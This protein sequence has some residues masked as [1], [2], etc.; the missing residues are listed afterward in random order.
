MLASGF[1]RTPADFFVGVPHDTTVQVVLPGLVNLRARGWF[2]GDVHAHLK[3]SPVDYGLTA[4]DAKYIAQAEGLAVLHLLDEGYEFTGNPDVHS[5]STTILY[6]SDE[7]RYPTYG[8]VSL[9]GL[10]SRVGAGCCP[11]AFYETIYDLYQEVH[12]QAGARLVLAHPHTT[13]NYDDLDD[14]PGTGLGRELP[15]LAALGALDGFELAS[16]SNNPQVDTSEWFDL[17]SAGFATP[18]AA[19]TDALL[20]SYDRPPPGGWRVYVHQG[21]G[22]P[23]DYDTWLSALAAG[24][25]F[26]TSFPLIPEF[27][28]GGHGM[29]DTLEVEGDSLV[30]PVHFEI[31]CASGLQGVTLLADGKTVWWSGF[32]G[33]PPT[34]SFDTSFVLRIPRPTWVALRVDGTAGA[35]LAASQAIAFT[36]A[37]HVTHGGVAI[38]RPEA[39]ID[40]LWSLDRLQTLVTT[41]YNWPVAWQRDTVLA[42]IAR[43]RLVYQAPFRDP[44]GPFALLSPLPNSA[45][46]DTLVW[47]SA[48][49]PDAG[50]F[51]TYELRVGTD[52]TLTDAWEMQTAGTWAIE[53]PLVP[54]SWYW[55]S[56]E[57]SDRVG[58]RT[59]STPAIARFYMPFPFETTLTVPAGTFS[60]PPRALPNP[61]CRAVRLQ[62]FGQ[63]VAI[64][65]MAGRRLA[66]CGHGIY[67]TAEGP[68]WD[69]TCGGHLVSPGV[70]LAR[71]PGQRHPVHIVRLR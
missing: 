55:W 33:T 45:A 31:W 9:P 6:F 38:P 47:E 43:A 34:T 27:S 58:D 3:H 15:V 20:D 44:P 49:D 69:G 7:C 25:S 13:N 71:S 18:P 17:L 70:Y 24:H 61:S 54:G 5:D 42:R 36:S 26:V 16:Y 23:L 66:E 50:D 40:W 65:D 19:G 29:G 56:V 46:H 57:A 64:Y 52:S 11:N 37:V 41:R 14:W 60:V 39:M 8:H 53:L 1:E 4:V 51:V 62:G 68:V 21:S 67:R 12:G 2:S 63:D 10:R 32:T 59:V 35:M 30:A 22:D 28:L 48:V